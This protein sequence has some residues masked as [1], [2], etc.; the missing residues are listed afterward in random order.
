MQT[1]EIKQSTTEREKLHSGKYALRKFDAFTQCVA[2][3]RRLLLCQSIV[4]VMKGGI[5]VVCKQYVGNIK[6]GRQK[7][8]NKPSN[9]LCLE[10]Q[11]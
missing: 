9:R 5:L 7:S 3:N 1:Y 6:E 10:W 4:D 11:C 2:Q 8:T